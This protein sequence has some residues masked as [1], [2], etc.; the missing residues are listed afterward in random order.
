MYL[1][2]FAKQDN[3][4]V[5]GV[6]KFVNVVE[7]KGGKLNE[8]TFKPSDFRDI[9]NKQLKSWFGTKEFRLADSETLRAKGG[10]VKVFGKSWKGAKPN[11]NELIWIQ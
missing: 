2:V 11:F 5:I 3:L 1:K 4:L 8:I 9:D 6:D 7:L 10:K